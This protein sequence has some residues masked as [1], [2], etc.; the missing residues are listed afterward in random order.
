MAYR[1]EQRRLNPGGVAGELPPIF[2]A[3]FLFVQLAGGDVQRLQSFRPVCL[4]FG[5]LSIIV[6]MMFVL[7]YF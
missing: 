7:I 1:N 4:Q 6:C 5:T 2:Q 3:D